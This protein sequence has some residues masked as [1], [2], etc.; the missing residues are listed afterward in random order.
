[1]NIQVV[2][3]T[4]SSLSMNTDESNKE[5]INE[6]KLGIGVSDQDKKTFVIVFKLKFCEN[7]VLYNIDYKT[8]FKADE[9]LD[10]NFTDTNFAKINAPAIAY[11]FLRS[12]LSSIS[13]LSGLPPVYLP[14]VN[15]VEF[16]K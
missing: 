8:L 11:P 6:L 5:D 4:I 12:A 1:M 2:N 16:S 7:S 13:V 10:E 14:T 3:N 15:F 9:E